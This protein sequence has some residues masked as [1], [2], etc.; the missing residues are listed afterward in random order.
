M[1]QRGMLLILHSFTNGADRAARGL[2]PWGELATLCHLNLALTSLPPS[3]CY[4]SHSL[5]TW[6][7]TT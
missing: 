1:T 2:S 7:L 5:S 4:L 3:P 6:P